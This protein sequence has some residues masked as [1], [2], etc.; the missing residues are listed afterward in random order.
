MKNLQWK[1][2][3]IVVV[4]ALSVWAFMPLGRKVKLGLDLRGGVHLVLKVKTDDG[5]AAP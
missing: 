1:I 2:L 4:T 5:R 3:A